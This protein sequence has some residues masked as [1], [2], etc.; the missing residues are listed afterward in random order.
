MIRQDLSNHTSVYRG[1]VY[2][3]PHQK[4]NNKLKRAIYDDHIPQE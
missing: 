4:R 3:C 2:T 1:D